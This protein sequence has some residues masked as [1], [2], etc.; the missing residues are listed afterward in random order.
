MVFATSRLDLYTWFKRCTYCLRFHSDCRLLLRASTWTRKG[1]SVKTKADVL[2]CRGVTFQKCPCIGSYLISLA[3]HAI[4]GSQPGGRGVGGGDQ[5]EIRFKPKIKRNHHIY[6]NFLN[7]SCSQ[8]DFLSSLY[9]HVPSIAS[10]LFFRVY[11]R[12]RKELNKNEPNS[13]VKFLW[14]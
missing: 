14:D 4:N 5:K 6:K 11:K 3:A 12:I 9:I 7:K 8:K 10:W 1:N 2:P 13:D